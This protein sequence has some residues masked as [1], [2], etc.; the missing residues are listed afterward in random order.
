MSTNV[1][2]KFRCAV[3][4]IEKALGILR[5]LIPRTTTTTVAF[6][7]PP[8]GSKKCKACTNYMYNRTAIIQSTST[9]QGWFIVTKSHNNT[10]QHNGYSSQKRKWLSRSKW[11]LFSWN[12]QTLADKCYNTDFCTNAGSTNNRIQRICFLCNCYFHRRKIF[13]KFSLIR[14]NVSNCIHI[15]LQK[16]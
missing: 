9:T 1:Y 14:W 16:C 13:F 3:L 10:L 12:L 2:A 8:S 15:H 4:H 5:E 11:A 7:D 6:W